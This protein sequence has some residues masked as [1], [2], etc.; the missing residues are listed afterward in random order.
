MRIVLVDSGIGLLSTAAALREARPDADLILS[1]DPD[2][3]PWGPRST[4][5][6]TRRVLAGARA[7]LAEGPDAVVVAC[8]TASVHALEPLRAELEPR[9]PVVGTVP[10]VKPAADRGGPFAIWATPATTGS[11]Y[12]R[13]LVERFARGTAVTPV[14]CPGLADAV[15]RADSSS[16]RDAVARAAERTPADTSAVVLGCTH[17]DLVEEWISAVLGD[18]VALFTAAGAVAAQTLRR[19]GAEA[20]PGAPRTGALRV[21]AS[22]RPAEMPE[23][24]LRYPAGALLAAEPVG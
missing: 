10:A 2:H 6:I 16:V 17:Y 23:A 7:A 5:E 19:L 22:G 20:R 4:A 18:G 1:M 12:Q 9:I 8:N 21:Y 11:P 3:M 24:A 14:A 13:G 15:E